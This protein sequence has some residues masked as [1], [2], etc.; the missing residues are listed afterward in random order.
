MRMPSRGTPPPRS[1][2]APQ[3]PAYIIY[4]SG[5]TGTPKGVAVTHNGIATLAA[6]HI[7]RLAITSHARVLQF[8]SLS[9]DAAMSEI[10]TALTAGAA[11]VV[12]AGER[13]GDAVARL[14]REHALTHALF[15]PA[16]VADLPE[17][18]RLLGLLGGGEACAPD[19]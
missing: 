10:A 14:V 18:L 9:F 15:P 5:S 13:G 6:A 16:L 17:D 7:D 8:A 19:G 11:L 4:T 3:H 2:L 12:S 1:G